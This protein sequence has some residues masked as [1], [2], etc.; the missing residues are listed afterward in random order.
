MKK[1]I[2]ITWLMLI[3]MI[4][5]GQEMYLMKVTKDYEGSEKV[6]TTE[7]IYDEYGNLLEM[8]T[9]QY[10]PDGV[11]HHSGSSYYY[12][13]D[14]IIQFYAYPQNFT[15][16]MVYTEDS[17]IRYSSQS[18]P[19]SYYVSDH[20]TNQIDSSR[21]ANSTRS[22]PFVWEED[23]LLSWGLGFEVSYYEDI[24]NPFYNA[25]KYLRFDY[26]S[27]RN[28]LEYF[29]ENSYFEVVET[30]NGYPTEV[31]NYYFGDFAVT[32][33]YEYNYIYVNTPEINTEQPEVLS[34]DYFDIMGRSIP[35]PDRG[36]FIER[37]TTVKGVVSN[38]YFIQ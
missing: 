25:F 20:V 24:L 34:V 19:T 4:V 9:E 16:D 22:R 29:A 1:L 6:S 33:Y 14:T 32:F 36:F 35:K 23:N 8:K 12:E 18:G 30:F 13:N 3:G 37:K 7:L 28:Y 31:R 11:P 38:K 21:Y 17:I 10:D 15:W 2:L 5:S 26:R 27:S